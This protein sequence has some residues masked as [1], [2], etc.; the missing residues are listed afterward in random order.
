MDP[1]INTFV[2]QVDQRA[3]TDLVRRLKSSNTIEVKDWQYRLLYSHCNAHCVSEVYTFSGTGWDRGIPNSWQ[4]ILKIW[5]GVTTGLD[6][7]NVL[8]RELFAYESGLL[9]QPASGLSAPRCLGA[10]QLRDHLSWLWLEHITHEN[11]STWTPSRYGLAARHLGAFNGAYL[12]R[13]KLPTYP[14]LNKKWTRQWVSEATTA[15]AH[16][17]KSLDHPLI[18]RAYP[19][20]NVEGLMSIYAD[21]DKLLGAL[22][23]LPQT[24]C[25]NDAFRRNLFAHVAAD[26]TDCT[27][28]VDWALVGIGA[29]GEEIAPL[30]A[31]IDPSLS[32]ETDTSIF[33]GY[34]NGL[35]DA[36]WY[37]QPYLARLGY[38]LTAALRYVLGSTRVI[39]ELALNENRHILMRQRKGL[40]I[41]DAMSYFAETQRFLLSLADEART[42]LKRL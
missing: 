13:H 37:G 26:G 25:H 33:E 5:R 30:I 23:D 2:E 28:A 19:A 42:L 31:E 29:I 14:W 15:I 36:G 4:L 17:H 12:L 40:S 1:E 27:V 3:I 7:T 38:L 21:R 22:E 8:L 11:L 41:E 10:A 24:L 35:R 34:I 20:S 16:L 32:L 6:D 9:E 18:A 39:L